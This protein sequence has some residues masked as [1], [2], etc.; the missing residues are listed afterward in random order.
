MDLREENTL[1]MAKAITSNNVEYSSRLTDLG[2]GFA[3]KIRLNNRFT[4]HQRLFMIEIFFKGEN[5]PSEKK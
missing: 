5:N 3:L 1:K 4:I 2:I